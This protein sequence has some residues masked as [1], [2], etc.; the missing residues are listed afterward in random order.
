M[1]RSPG[2]VAGWSFEL[3]DRC[4]RQ[5]GSLELI[6][7]QRHEALQ[8]LPSDSTASKDY[9]QTGSGHQDDIPASDCSS[10]HGPA[11]HARRVSRRWCLVFPLKAIH[12][13]LSAARGVRRAD[14]VRLISIWLRHPAGFTEISSGSSDKK[15][16][17]IDGF[18][19]KDERWRARTF[20]SGCHRRFV[21]GGR[22]TELGRRKSATGGFGL[23]KMGFQ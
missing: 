16:A 8:R 18:F 11:G 17:D 23:P 9:R 21:P 2:P 3:S 22:G 14:D 6:L 20:R 7:I 13:G 4:P 1:A 19:V 15:V 12:S 10:F 5:R